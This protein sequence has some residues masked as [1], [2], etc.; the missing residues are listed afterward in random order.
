MNRVVSFFAEG[1]AA[2]EG[3]H[4]YVGYRG[5]RPVVAHDNPRLAG[6]RTIVARAANDAARSAGW[7]P[8]Y[9]GPVAVQA[10]FY[11]PHPKRP[12]FPDRAATKPDLD[13]LARAVGDALAAPGGILL[14]DSRIV[15]WVL[16]KRW[17]SDGQPPGVHVAVT[18]IDD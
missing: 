3:S 4:R 18:A 7:A 17:A 1:V 10:H 6:W 15:T 12:R 14:E 8:Q 5:G 11:L 13:K 16:T 2:P 9:D